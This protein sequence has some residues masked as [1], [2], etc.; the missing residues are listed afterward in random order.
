[1][2]EVGHVLEHSRLAGHDGQQTPTTTSRRYGWEVDEN[3]PRPEISPVN[4]RPI[5]LPQST[6]LLLNHTLLLQ[7]N[8]RLHRC[9]RRLFLH[10]LKDDR[11]HHDQIILHLQVH[12]ILNRLYH[13]IHVARWIFSM[14][15]TRDAQPVEMETI[16][17][18]SDVIALA[19]AVHNGAAS[20][21]A[22][23][24][25]LNGCWHHQTTALNKSLMQVI[26]SSLKSTTNLENLL[27]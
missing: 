14:I 15:Y 19:G 11:D 1:M 2:A 26:F 5:H 16:I 3:E 21:K 18:A 24:Q 9:L 13:V 12:S 20:K 6:P 17:S 4:P 27:Q 25:R 7:L 23:K 10:E 22:H 8:V